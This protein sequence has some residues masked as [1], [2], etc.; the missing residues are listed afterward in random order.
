MADKLIECGLMGIVT[1]VIFFFT[2]NMALRK[3]IT[4]TWYLRRL[5][6]KKKKF[7]QKFNERNEYWWYFM[8]KLITTKYGSMTTE[9][10]QWSFSLMGLKL[11]SGY[12]RT[13]TKMIKYINAHLDI[14]GIFLSYYTYDHKFV[15]MHTGT[16]FLI[17]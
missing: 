6:C 10:Q 17:G 5:V 13:A 9:R 16:L 8:G 12:Y 2:L 14:G 1:R 7:Q 15:L 3:I 4:L 11:Q